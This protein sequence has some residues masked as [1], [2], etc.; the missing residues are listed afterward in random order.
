MSFTDAVVGIAKAVNAMNGRGRIERCC[1]QLGW[2]IDDRKGDRITLNFKCPVVGTRPVFIQGGDEP[3]VLFAAY[4][5]TIFDARRVPDVATNFALWQSSESSMG[6]WQISLNDED[7]LFFALTYNALG[8][9]LDAAALKY[10]CGGM[11]ATA[12]DF[13]A[14]MK[15]EGYLR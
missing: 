8:A 12:S 3:L 14:K 2:S 15:R 5:L 1:E 13:D 4:S 7:E 6:K 11:A 10:I 9:G